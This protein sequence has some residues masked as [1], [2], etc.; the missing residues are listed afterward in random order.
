MVTVRK[1]KLLSTSSVIAENT[2]YYEFDVDTV[3]ELPDP[4]YNGTNV[5]HGS[6]ATIINSGEI[7]RINGDGEWKSQS[8]SGGAGLPE[9]TS[10]DNGDVLTVVEGVWSKAKVPSIIEIFDATFSGNPYVSATLLNSKTHE[11]IFNSYLSGKIPI[12]RCS[13]STDAIRVLVIP[14]TRVRHA[15]TS[16]IMVFSI[17]D[18][19]ANGNA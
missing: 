13:S 14:F 3:D 17:G 18:R 8:T 4:Y 6:K 16:D 10:E 7:Y 15:G 9:V 2:Y 5:A 1:S 11:D 12:I 19:D